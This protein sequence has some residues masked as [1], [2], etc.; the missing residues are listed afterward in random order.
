MHPSESLPAGCLDFFELIKTSDVNYGDLTQHDISP[1][2]MVF[3]PFSSGTTGLP[4][5]V[6]LTH[7][8]VTSNCEQTQIPFPTDTLTYQDSLPCV[9][10]FFHIYGLTVV[11]LSKIGQGSRLV[12]LPQ[13]KPEDLIKALHEYKGSVLNLVPPIGKF[14]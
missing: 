11:M 8:N 12:T 14:K 6:M 9:L 4:K 10:P 7:S 2:D 5:G 3:L 13:F 1:H